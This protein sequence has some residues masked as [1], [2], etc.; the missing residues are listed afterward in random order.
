MKEKPQG[1]ESDA[2]SEIESI[3]T[4]PS[5]NSSWASI[6]KKSLKMKVPKGDI[7][8]DLPKNKVNKN[9]KFTEPIENNKE[10]KEKKN[11]V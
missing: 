4:I 2:S 7:K 11:L 5:T 10:Q 8:I 3:K 9:K 6:V 1:F